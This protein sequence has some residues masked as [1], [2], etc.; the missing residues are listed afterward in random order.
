ML[1]IPAPTAMVSPLDL[2]QPPYI[3]LFAVLRIVEHVQG[4]LVEVVIHKHLIICRT[5]KRRLVKKICVSSLVGSLKWTVI[6]YRES[7]LKFHVG[8]EIS[9]WGR[10]FM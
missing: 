4:I 8:G 2:P 9:C 10:N 1:A 6:L 3:S 5:F 7:G